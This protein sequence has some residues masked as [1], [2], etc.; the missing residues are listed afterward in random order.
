[1]KPRFPKN[2]YPILGR[3]APDIA[4]PSAVPLPTVPVPQN[5][6]MCCPF[7]QSTDYVRRGTRTKKHEVVQLFKCK[8][9]ECE[10]TFTDSSVK[11]RRYPLKVIID[12][13]SYYNLGFTR[14]KVC[15]IIHQL[16]KDIKP[17]PET[18]SRWA[19]E[20]KGICTYSKMRQYGMKM[21]G[22]MNVLEVVTMAH[23]Q[24]YRFR[25]HK[26]KIRLML[27]DYRNRNFFPLK[28]YL[29]AISTETPHQLFTSGERISDVR[30]MFSTADMIVTAKT[31]YANRIAAFALK[32]VTQNKE[33]HEGIQKFMIANDSVTVAT[34]VPVYIRRE[35]IEYMQNTL[36]FQIVGEGGITFRRHSSREEKKKD[37]KMTIE[38]YE[39]RRR[40]KAG[41]AG[42]EATSGTGTFEIPAMLTGH[43]DIVQVRNG[44]IHLL[45]YKPNAKKEKPIE[46]LTWYALAMSRLTG[47]KLYEF[48]CAWFDETDYFEFYPLHVVKKIQSKKKRIVR[49]RTG[50]Q[51]EI[52]QDDVIQI[53]K[54][55]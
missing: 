31:N 29:D 8:N 37:K 10:K 28:E 27:E 50:V 15:G 30:S 12:A 36:N 21:Y 5:I 17:E 25:Y 11:G 9:Q 34:E 48:K 43:V 49:Y 22:P 1:M 26:A 38:E 14:E 54:R 18:I 2:E 23:H 51:A 46:Q 39:R 13:I 53:I 33:R 6:K 3:P 24:L 42:A 19:E 20:Y 52:P 47:L 4:N 55:T 41:A 45:D 44:M 32:S 16:H 35:D 40:E 7:C